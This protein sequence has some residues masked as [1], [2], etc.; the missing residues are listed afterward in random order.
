[1]GQC[2]SKKKKQK[3]LPSGVDL[4]RHEAKESLIPRPSSPTR[5]K[6]KPQQMDHKYQADDELNE[7]D[8]NDK[9]VELE[10]S[11]KEN[12]LGQTVDFESESE[13]SESMEQEGKEMISSV[14]K[15]NISGDAQDDS[16]SSEDS[17]DSLDN[18]GQI[19]TE[20]MILSSKQSLEASNNVSMTSSLN[21]SA[22]LPITQSQEARK[23]PGQLLL[24]VFPFVIF[25]RSQSHLRTTVFLF[26]YSDPLQ[27]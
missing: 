27:S 8:L 2:L 22:D 5:N 6:H 18:S 19:M 3:T 23:C 25:L 14:K 16:S 20:P 10:N 24:F 21:S 15:L 12:G 1:M 13:D 26:C 17:N 4:N 9:N 11:I 7:I